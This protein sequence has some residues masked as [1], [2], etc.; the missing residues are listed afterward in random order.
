MQEFFFAD[1][2]TL[3]LPPPPPPP[4]VLCR[5]LQA[6]RRAAM[7]QKGGRSKRDRKH[8]VI[9]SLKHKHGSQAGLAEASDADLAR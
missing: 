1:V 5:C 3:L 4:L 8:K 9:Q 6:A 7:P 2:P